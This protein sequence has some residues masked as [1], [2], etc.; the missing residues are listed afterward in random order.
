[1]GLNVNSYVPDLRTIS[2]ISVKMMAITK[3]ARKSSR[4]AYFSTGHNKCL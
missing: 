1:M 4:N 3:P 2:T